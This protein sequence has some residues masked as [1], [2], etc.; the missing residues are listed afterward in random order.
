MATDWIEQYTE[1]ASKKS[2]LT[3]RHFHQNIALTLAAGSIA[4]RC[5]VQLPYGRIFPNIYTLIVGRTSIFAK[6]TA[7]NLARQICQQVMPEKVFSHTSTPE[8]L[9]TDLSGQMPTNFSELSEDD[10]KALKLSGKWGGRRLFIL[11]EAGMFFNSLQKDYQQGTPDMFMKLYD[12]GNE[13]LKHNA[14]GAGMQIISNYA[15]SVLFATTPYAIRIL[16]SKSDFWMSGFWNR[17]NFVGAHDMTEWMEGSDA[18]LPPEIP[19]TLKSISSGWLD[20]YFDKPYSVPIDIKVVKEHT[21]AQ[22]NLR[23]QSHENEN[24]K[25]DGLMSHLSTKHLKTALIYAILEAKGTKPHLQMKHWEMA[26]PLV[27]GWY[28]DAQTVLDS[29]KYSERH[30]D[31]EKI[32]KYIKASNPLGISSRRIQQ[33]TGKS[34]QELKSILLPLEDLGFIARKKEGRT[35][36]WIMGKEVEWRTKEEGK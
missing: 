4:A 24:E 30:T 32:V 14:R 28:N 7:L 6:T 29:L 20:Q 31:E 9:F 23:A 19:N 1:W 27:S 11:D 17:W 33:S 26:R 34:A 3:P 35:E 22:K 8:A 12:A 13:P 15:L 21:E 16:L 36:L 10:R 2:P 18:P 25:F 5:Y